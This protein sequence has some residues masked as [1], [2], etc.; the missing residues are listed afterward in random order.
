MRNGGL[1]NC[2]AQKFRDFAYSMGRAQCGVTRAVVETML[3]RRSIDD[4]YPDK[5]IENLYIGM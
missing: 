5:V 3:V 2:G 4:Y 1:G